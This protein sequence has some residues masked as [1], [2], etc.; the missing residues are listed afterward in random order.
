MYTAEIKVKDRSYNGLIPT[1]DEM[2]T[3]NF[4]DT[5]NFKATNILSVNLTDLTSGFS[6]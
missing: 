5:N 3:V 6:K 2:N 4:L 1:I